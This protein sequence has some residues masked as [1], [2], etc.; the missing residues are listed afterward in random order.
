MTLLGNLGIAK[1]NVKLYKI[2]IKTLDRNSAD[3]EIY[4]NLCF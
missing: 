2:I 1:V 3:K 4:I